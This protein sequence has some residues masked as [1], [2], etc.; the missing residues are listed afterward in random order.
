MYIKRIIIMKMKSKLNRKPSSIWNSAI[1]TSQC[2]NTFGQ[3]ALSSATIPRCHT[4]STSAH[5][6]W[7]TGYDVI[8]REVSA[9]LDAS[10]TPPS[11]EKFQPWIT[12]VFDVRIVILK[13]T[14][15]GEDRRSTSL[16]RCYGGIVYCYRTSCGLDDAQSS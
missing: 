10:V 15:L 5:Q 12:E 14:F 7:Q 6:R 1:M 11:E 3:S 9:S 16:Q 13:I 4:S 8:K 2:T